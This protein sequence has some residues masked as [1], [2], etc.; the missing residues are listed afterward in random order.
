MWVKDETHLS[1]FGVCVKLITKVILYT[2]K[3]L[4]V[5]KV[6]T[7][8]FQITFKFGWNNKTEQ[9]LMYEKQKQQIKNLKL[10]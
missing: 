5:I 4:H 6:F 8:V 2:Q 7:L 9:I 3:T 1:Y 10:Y